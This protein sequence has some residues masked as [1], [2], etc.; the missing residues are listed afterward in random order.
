MSHPS[1]AAMTDAQWAFEYEA[2][3]V[4]EE[5]ELETWV[6]LLGL[7]LPGRPAGQPFLP[8]SLVMGN[9]RLLE[10]W[11]KSKDQD[12]LSDED[13]DALSARLAAGEGDILPAGKGD[14]P[15]EAE[16]RAAFK[17]QRAAALAG[18]RLPPDDA[19]RLVGVSDAEAAAD[20]D[21]PAGWMAPVEI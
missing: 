12:A 3:R 19:A 7:K 5:E 15:G 4:R 21:A 16:L 1:V 11:L 10:Q 20:P 13:F 2:L 18:K 14:M 9:P 6:H 8:A 17:A